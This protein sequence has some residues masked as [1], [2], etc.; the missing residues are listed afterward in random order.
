MSTR[1]LI[2][3]LL[4]TSTCV[5][6]ADVTP[7]TPASS[8]FLSSWTTGDGSSVIGS[9]VLSNNVSLIGGVAHGS[10]AG[11]TQDLYQKASA[12]AAQ[13][14]GVVKVSYSQGIQG[15]FL[16]RTSNAVLVAMLG[17]SLSA[18]S[19]PAG[20]SITSAAKAT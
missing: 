20:A 8:G 12:S 2:A 18:V 5:A 3:A 1:Y 17:D 4:M 7:A 15:D 14:N 16:T 9:G 6:H 13:T 19:S 10:D 11:L